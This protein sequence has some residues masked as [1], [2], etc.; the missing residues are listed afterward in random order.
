MRRS[1]LALDQEPRIAWRIGHHGPCAAVVG[2]D[3]Q[4]R[5]T[6][7]DRRGEPEPACRPAALAL[8]QPAPTTAMPR[9]RRDQTHHQRIP[10]ST[11]PHPGQVPAGDVPPRSSQVPREPVVASPH[12]RAMITARRR[13]RGTA[14]STMDLHQPGDDG[15]HGPRVESGRVPLHSSDDGPARGWRCCPSPDRRQVDA[16][17]P[18]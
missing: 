1:P 4:R 12:T 7:V 16:R 5:T 8:D 13:Q 3:A 9:H 2:T 17:D 6:P 11:L 10:L 14:R 18:D 15:P